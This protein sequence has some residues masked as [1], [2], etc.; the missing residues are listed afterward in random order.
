MCKILA[1]AQNLLMRSCTSK[2][3][4]RTPDGDAASV[5]LGSHRLTYQVLCVCCTVCVLAYSDRKKM[6]L[7]CFL[8]VCFP[9]AVIEKWIV[10]VKAL[11]YCCPN[12]DTAKGREKS[13]H[14]CALFIFRT[15]G[16]QGMRVKRSKVNLGASHTQFIKDANYM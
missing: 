4:D 13:I 14:L 2:T 10:L 11:S 1:P 12:R 8:C 3:R 16:A 9:D 6:T 5:P 7:V 15:E